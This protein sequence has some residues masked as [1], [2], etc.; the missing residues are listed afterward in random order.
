MSR[1]A[2]TL[3]LTNCKGGKGSSRTGLACAIFATA[4]RLGLLASLLTWSTGIGMGMAMGMEKGPQHSRA[5]LS[6]TLRLYRLPC[7]V[8]STPARKSN[9]NA[10]RSFLI[11]LRFGELLGRTFGFRRR[12][13]LGPLSDHRKR[14]GRAE[15]KTA[16]DTFNFSK[17]QLTDIRLAH[18]I[19]SLI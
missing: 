1:V 10:K 18:S 3:K 12:V 9:L 8:L 5:S 4:G 7:T 6:S 14:K 16:T 15:M 11:G 17:W 2:K 19:H 13:K